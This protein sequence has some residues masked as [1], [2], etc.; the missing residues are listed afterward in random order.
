MLH[1]PVDEPAA[2]AG[3]GQAVNGSDRGFRQND[4]DAFCHGSLSLMISHPHYL[5]TKDVC[6]IGSAIYDGK[7]VA[8]RHD[9]LA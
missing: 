9:P 8:F 3:P 5:H 1:I 6:Q 7:G 2:L 4:V